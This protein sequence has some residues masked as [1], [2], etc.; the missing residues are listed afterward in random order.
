MFTNCAI[1]G[2]SGIRESY[3]D[4]ENANTSVEVTANGPYGN[5]LVHT[6]EGGHY[7]IS[8]LGNGT[9]SLTFKK[10]GYGDVRM[11]GIQL[12]G[13]DTAFVDQVSLFKIY[14]F[15]KPVLSNVR[16][17]INQRYGGPNY[18]AVVMETTLSASAA[19]P[20]PLPVVLYL[21]TLKNVSYKNFAVVFPYLQVAYSDRGAGKIDFYFSPTMYLHFKKGTLVYFQAYV[22]NPEEYRSGYFDNYLGVQQLSTL[23]TDRHSEVMSFV[24]P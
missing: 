23:K 8:G 3:S 18:P 24:M 14:D 12:F 2:Y 15:P 13:D 1:S 10:V 6:A 7:F 9:Y 4:N 20:V 5:S 11:Y 21:D 22:A 17:E 16:V 19:L